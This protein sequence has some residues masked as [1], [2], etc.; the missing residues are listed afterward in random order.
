MKNIHGDYLKILSLVHYDERFI[1][2]MMVLTITKIHMIKIAALI[3]IFSSL[4]IE[5]ATF[6]AISLVENG[7]RKVAVIEIPDPNGEKLENS[8]IKF[9]NP[10]KKLIKDSNGCYCFPEK[11]IR[12]AYV[13]AYHH[14]SK[15]LDFFRTQL[16]RLGLPLNIQITMKLKMVPEQQSWGMVS[17]E[18]T[19]EF[20][21]PT[22]TFDYTILAHEVAHV[23]HQG[24]GGSAYVSTE[25]DNWFYE[26]G[27]NEGTANILAALY[28]DNPIISAYSPLKNSIDVFV[29]EPDQVFTN[30]KQYEDALANKELWATFPEWAKKIEQFFIEQQSSEDAYELD[31]PSPY[32]HS[33]IVNQPLWR[34][35]KLFGRDVVLGIYLKTL[36]QVNTV[37]SYSEL[38]QAVLENTKDHIKLREFLMKEFKDRGLTVN[39][40]L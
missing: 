9:L 27:L 14:V 40:N 19:I 36:S 38:A 39:L 13:Q 4:S 17:D 26:Q 31:L 22:P 1:N 11:D 2:N 20:E 3:F 16:F 33:N 25:N 8:F 30:R 6:G 7:K 23:I 18:N 21:F 35:S 12:F 24:L 37:N 10:P 34:A 15:Q 28:L 32:F 29:R 5:A